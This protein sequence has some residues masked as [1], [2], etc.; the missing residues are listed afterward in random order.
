AHSEPNCATSPHRDT[1][2]VVRNAAAC[3]LLDAL[4]IHDKGVA[5][6]STAGRR[7]ACWLQ[8]STG[9]RPCGSA[10]PGFRHLKPARLTRGCLKRAALAALLAQAVSAGAGTWPARVLH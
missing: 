7:M 4:S 10:R 1:P 6:A 8:P 5:A 9:P 2:R 3:G